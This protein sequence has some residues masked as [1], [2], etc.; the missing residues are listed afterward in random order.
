MIKKLKLVR[1][2]VKSLTVK[3][4]LKAGTSVSACTTNWGVTAHY[5]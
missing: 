4:G 3:T 5:P 1:I 2:T